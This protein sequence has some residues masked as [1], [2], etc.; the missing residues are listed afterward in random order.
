M[1]NINKKQKKSSA[2][3]LLNFFTEQ[4]ITQEVYGIETE[5]VIKPS[6][7]FPEFL[8]FT[9]STQ[10]RKEGCPFH[11]PPSQ[12][13]TATPHEKKPR[14]PEQIAQQLTDEALLRGGVFTVDTLMDWLMRRK[15]MAPI[16]SRIAVDGT[17]SFWQGALKGTIAYSQ[18]LSA[19]MQ[20]DAY[21]LDQRYKYKFF[22][23]YTFDAKA[24]TAD[25]VEAWATYTDTISSIC[26][27]A[28]KTLHMS[29]QW[30][31]ESTYN[32]YPHVH[33]VFYTNELRTKGLGAKKAGT[34]LRA[35]EEYE[36]FKK[37]APAPVFRVEWAKGKGS[38]KYL[39][40][41]IKKSAK[42]TL[43]K[44]PNEHK[45]KKVKAWIKD[46]LTLM[47]PTIVGCRG[48][49]RSQWWRVAPLPKE[50]AEL[51]PEGNFAAQSPVA[52]LYN[53]N[54]D[55]HPPFSW[56]FKPDIEDNFKFQIWQAQWRTFLRRASGVQGARLRRAALDWLLNNSEKDCLASMRAAFSLEHK[57]A[58]E[59][60][61]NDDGTYKTPPPDVAMANTVPIGCVDCIIKRI[62]ARWRGEKV[63]MLVKNPEENGK[64]V[65][66]RVEPAPENRDAATLE[67][68]KQDSAKKSLENSF[69]VAGY[70]DVW[71][72][73]F[74]P[75]RAWSPALSREAMQVFDEKEAKKATEQLKEQA[76]KEASMSPD[77]PFDPK[78]AHYSRGFIV[79][80][81]WD[82]ETVGVADGVKRWLKV[83]ALP[84][85]KVLPEIETTDDAEEAT[86]FDK[87]EYAKVYGEV[88]VKKQGRARAYD[89]V[90]NG[91]RN[92]IVDGGYRFDK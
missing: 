79:R 70:S 9:D 24:Y 20:H 92:L 8:H 6:P 61:E 34:I 46:V 62:F 10:P 72:R 13:Q 15:R 1:A 63:S 22:V 38:S 71:N 76:I 85:D 7:Y 23:T 91:Y 73:R 17:L 55:W 89:I 30:V 60:Y 37:W 12:Y 26:E 2:K 45:K 56:L 32:G 53:E 88:F 31:T 11:L 51:P 27:K 74:A 57:K 39:I 58:L 86:I 78:T 54:P 80:V 49:G 28:R 14:T 81:A 50:G 83:G 75:A 21:E 35:G 44:R 29:Y 90:M 64:K 36:F 16:L 48:Y 67:R 84:D 87:E 5:V 65:A 42:P 25:R 82:G 52:S 43:L 68:E 77:K 69:Y 41:Y 40:K 18:K 66:S 3:E 47:C 33:I 4:L 59:E 19:T